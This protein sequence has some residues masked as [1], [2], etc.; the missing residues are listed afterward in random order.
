MLAT[1]EE[2]TLGTM[3]VCSVTSPPIHP[4]LPVLGACWGTEE[5]GWKGGSWI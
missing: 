4:F 5:L 2:S 3:K 1:V